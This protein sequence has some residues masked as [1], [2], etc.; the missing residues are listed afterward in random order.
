ML[1]RY[2]IV[3]RLESFEAIDKMRMYHLHETSTPE[4][5]CVVAAVYQDTV[6]FYKFRGDPEFDFVEV[7]K[8]QLRELAR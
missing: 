3:S 2:Y 8:S 1:A 7:R 6:R 5:P 4:N